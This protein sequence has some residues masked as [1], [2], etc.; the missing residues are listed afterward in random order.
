LQE[1]WP[2]L[3][4]LIIFRRFTEEAGFCR[5]GIGGKT[6]KSPYPRAGV[7]GTN[8]ARI[9][10]GLGMETV[11]MNKG[12]E[13]LQRIDEIFM[14][15]A[16]TIPLETYTIAEEISSGGYY[17]RSCSGSRRQDPGADKKNHARSN[18]KGICDS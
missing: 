14:G 2:L 6:C 4:E 12:T 5:P 3:W 18:E 7:V 13:R 11:V 17:N 10:I 15:R 9:S 16:K 1:E 8:A